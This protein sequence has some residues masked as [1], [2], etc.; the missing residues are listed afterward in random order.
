MKV[1]FKYSFSLSDSA[2]RDLYT[3]LWSRQIALTDKEF[4]EWQFIS[5]PDNNF[6]DHCVVAVVDECVVGVMGLNVRS[7]NLGGVNKRGA[8]LTTWIVDPNF[9]GLGAGA[10]MLAFIQAEFEV[11][12]GMGITDQAL[13]IYMK[14]GFRFLGS[15]PRFL[16]VKDLEI[17]EKFGSVSKLGRQLIQKWQPQ[18][19]PSMIEREVEWSQESDIQSEFNGFDRSSKSLYW[20]YS[21][22]PYFKYHSV[23]VEDLGRRCVVIFRVESCGDFN[24]MRIIDILGHQNNY[25]LALK[26][27]DNYL[28]E[29]T[30]ALAD[31]FCTSG[32]VNRHFIHANWFSVLD[33]SYVNFPHLFQPIELR[34]PATTSMVYWS[35]NDQLSL[36]DTSNMYIT[37]ADCDFDRPTVSAI[38]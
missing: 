19:S 14:M 9:S 25:D 20:R 30:I 21:C 29:N 26:F 8:E 37:K 33:D 16:R 5:P 28:I 32:Q 22:H 24:I 13:G 38:N 23:S 17:V 2:V 15:I 4:Y 18:V 34:C 3:R 36:C 11:L 1:G 27:I 31:F 6:S 35:K 10:K 7:F 12:I